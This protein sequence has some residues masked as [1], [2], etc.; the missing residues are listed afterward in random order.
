MAPC[1]S[2]S[3]S[4]RAFRASRW[5]R[6][7][8]SSRLGRG[9]TCSWRAGRYAEYPSHLPADVQ[10]SCRFGER[11]VRDH[12]GDGPAP[13]RRISSASFGHPA[14]EV[15]ASFSP[16]WRIGAPSPSGCSRCRSLSTRAGLPVAAPDMAVLA[17]GE[18]C[19]HL[20]QF[21]DVHCRPACGAVTL[22]IPRIVRVMVGHGA[23]AVD[24]SFAHR[25]VH[26]RSFRRDCPLIGQEHPAARCHLSPAPSVAKLLMG[27]PIGVGLH[28]REQPLLGPAVVA[29][30]G[31]VPV[32]LRPWS[33]PCPRRVSR[34]PG[35]LGAAVG[36]RP[37]ISVPGVIRSWRSPCAGV[38]VE[39]CSSR[40]S[41]RWLV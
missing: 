1:R 37:R 25:C 20:F 29:A 35:H 30:S 11:P 15:D 13:V 16:R 6:W 24:A 19:E 9:R 23:G 32:V 31:A 21:V 17:V 4:G 40:S 3:A 22:D 26:P 2:G 7:R 36:H 18:R 10:A 39:V 5:R 8:G 28:V 14:G 27:P 33:P 41:M 34:R 38:V 12:V